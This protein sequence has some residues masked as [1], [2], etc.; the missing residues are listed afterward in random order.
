MKKRLPAVAVVA[1]MALLSCATTDGQ[2]RNLD[3]A[4]RH[5]VAELA[6]RI[7][8]GTS[9]AVVAMH[10][11][12]DRMSDYLI[13][14]TMDAFVRIGGFAVV[15][16]VDLEHS[17]EELNFSMTGEVSDETQQMVGRR[18]GAQYIVVGALEQ[19]G[20]NFRFRA[21]VT[22]TERAVVLAAS[23]SGVPR[24]DILVAS[25]LGRGGTAAQPAVA[26]EPAPSPG[27]ACVEGGSFGRGNPLHRVTVS[28]FYMSRFQV[29]QGEWYDV[30]GTRPSFFDGMNALDVDWNSISASPT[31]NW[32]NLPVESVSWFDAVEFA[33]RLSV[34][35]GLTPAYSIAGTGN[36]RVVSWNRT[37]NG[38][39]LPTEAE[40]EFAARG[41]IVC[42]ENFKFSGSNNAWEVAWYEGN[43]G[44]RTHP[45]GT[46]R[47]NALGI[48]DMSGN[49]WEWV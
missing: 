10:S 19:H 37:A 40:W 5:V 36:D 41:G 46:L 32:R 8:E 12:S 27:F 34:A 42:R 22:H 11:S 25:M 23:N 14:E 18:V 1:A 17:A 47:P 16:R 26:Q 7:D 44:W 6:E 45:V 2:F 13:N 33:N 28:G 24:N 30:M 43:S 39:R 15:D 4:I 3:S 38:Y 9:I 35:A 31:L 20:R 29:T 49:V 48:H 21:R